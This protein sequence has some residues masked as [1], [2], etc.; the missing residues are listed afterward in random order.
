MNIHSHPE[1]EER[2]RADIVP[3]SGVLR[4]KLLALREQPQ[5]SNNNIA[6]SLGVS[7]SVVSQYLNDS[8]CIY[9]GDVAKLEL[10]IDD[11]LRNESRRKASGVDT[12][13][14]DITL[15]AEKALESIRRRNVIGIIMEKSGVGK[16]R[17]L[18]LYHQKNP[19]SIFFATSMWNCTKRDAETFMFKI[20]G[21]GGWDGQTKYAIHSINVLRGSGRLIIIDDAH[22]LHHTAL[23][24][25]VQFAEATQMPLVFCGIDKLLAVIEADPQIFSRI[26][27]NYRLV[28]AEGGAD[29]KS[30]VNERI[31]R[32]HIGKIAPDINGDL[33]QLLDYCLQVAAK[34]GGHRSVFNQLKTAAEIKALATKPMSWP[35]AFKSAHEVLIRPYDLN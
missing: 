9:S 28:S 22:Y 34:A 7:S 35:S 33:E 10:R 6:K 20:A 31:I 21:R 27:P 4:E 23:L 8:G 1:H 13:E 30:L 14:C 19:T 2:E 11:F 32:Q 25:W 5:W 24:W 3:C 26:G 12:V 18:E 29:D 16:T 15:Q 17:A